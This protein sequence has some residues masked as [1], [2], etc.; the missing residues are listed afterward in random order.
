MQVIALGDGKFRAVGF[1]GG[2]PGDGWDGGEREESEASRAGD[3][4]V[5][6]VKQD[7]AAS[8]VLKD[9][10]LTIRNAEGEALGK[11]QR[12]ERES[13]TIG[14]KPPAGAVVLFDGSSV[15][16]FQKG[17]RKTEEGLLM[18]GVRT[19]RRDFKDFQL[20]IEFRLP[21][22]PKARGQGRGNSGMYLLGTENQ[23]LDSFGLSGEANVCGGL[24]KWRRPDVNMCFPPLRWQT[25]D[26]DYTAAKDGKP[27]RMTVKQNGVVIH[28]KVELKKNA[29][30]GDIHLQNHGNPV[31][32]RNFWVLE[33]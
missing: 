1:E 22:K 17:A 2:L 25:Y 23:M 21:Y 7:G 29:E 27:A 33:R 3:G 26:V 10:A 15:E 28:D 12:V 6:F 4:S 30:A 20:H 14:A 8:A 16:A 19:A 9:G 5:S 32:Y 31:R 11:L 18:E 13:P 24:Y